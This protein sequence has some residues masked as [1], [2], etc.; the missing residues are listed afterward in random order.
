MAQTSPQE[1]QDAPARKRV[2]LV[3]DD[4]EIVEAMKLAPG[5]GRPQGPRR[6]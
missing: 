2:L 1:K 4:R 6:P 5:G 3:D